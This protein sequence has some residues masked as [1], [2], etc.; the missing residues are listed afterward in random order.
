MNEIFILTGDIKTGK[1]TTLLNWSNN[2]NDTF[3]VLSPVVDGKRK[4]VNVFT[5]DAFDMEAVG[6][7]YKL[8][9]GKYEFSE[10]AFVSAT[11]II[12]R[13]SHQTKG[14]LIIDE[15]GPLELKETGLYEAIKFALQHSKMKIILVVRKSLVDKVQ[16]FFELKNVSVINK[17][18]L[19]LWS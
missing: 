9:V 1:T 2:R 11:E 15:V 6:D 19:H 14:Y 5:S 4:F 3:G 13:S 8:F 18:A 16:E 7:E 10:K 12:V 17:E